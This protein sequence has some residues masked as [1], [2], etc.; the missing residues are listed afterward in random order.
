MKL[1][2]PKLLLTAV[3]AAFLPTT[4]AADSISISFGGT[5]MD[6][7]TDETS[8]LGGITKDGWNIVNIANTNGTAVDNQKGETAGTLVMNNIFGGWDSSVDSTN[9]VTGVV[10]RN[11]IDI[12]NYGGGNVHTIA[13]THNYW[14]AD[15]TYYMSGDAGGTYAPMVINGNTYINGTDNILDEGENPAW[16]SR[17]GVTEYNEN[18]TITVTGLSGGTITA[19]NVY[20]SETARATLGGMQVKDNSE[21]T[22]Y[23]TTLK[24]GITAAAD[25]SWTRDGKVSTYDDI[26]AGKK[27]LG[28]NA[29]AEGSTLQLTGGE[30]IDSIAAITNTV[31][32]QSD[33]A[34]TIYDLYTYSGA[35]IVLDTTATVNSIRGTGNITISS[36]GLLKTSGSGVASSLHTLTGSGRIEVTGAFYIKGNATKDAAGNPYEP[37]VPLDISYAGTIA[38]DADSMLTIGSNVTGGY[39]HAG[40]AVNMDDMTIELN[41]GGIHFNGGNSTLGTLVV[42]GTNTL[43]TEDSRVDGEGLTIKNLKIQGDLNLTVHWKGTLRI[44][45]ITENTG[46]LTNAATT[47]LGADENSI[48]NLSGTVK[49]T[50]K[51]TLNGDVRISE[52][53]TKFK[54]VKEGENRELSVNGTDG[55]QTITDNTYLLIDN[56]NGTVTLNPETALYQGAS[57]KLTQDTTTG[58][59]TFIGS[60]SMDT[61]YRVNTKDVTF[62]G[63]NASDHTERATG[64]IVAK[65][66]TLT[67]AGDGKEVTAEDILLNTTGEGNVT[68]TTDVRLTAQQ[69]SQ[70]TG[71]LTVSNCKLELAG[72]NDNFA[73][74]SSFKESVTL[75][76]AKVEF[77]NQADTFTNVTVT[78]NGASLELFDMGAP[79]DNKALT[80]AGTTTL[81]GDLNLTSTWNSQLHI[82]K[83]KGTGNL[84]IND[85]ETRGYENFRMQ[86]LVIN[87]AGADQYSGQIQIHENYDKLN[88]TVAENAGVNVALINVD[89]KSGRNQIAAIQ[90]IGSGNTITL[91]GVT[92]Y[93]PEGYTFV[94]DIVLK[95]TEGENAKAALEITDG[96]TKET[97]EFSGKVSGS[98]NFLINKPTAAVHMTYK[99]SGDVSQWEGSMEV[100]GGEHDVVYTD[101]N[102][103]A[104]TA[105]VV[106]N[107]SIKSR[108]K[109]RNNV[110]FDYS[111][112]AT[113]KS[114]FENGGNGLYLTVKN[115]SKDATTFTSN[116]IG[117]NKLTVENGKA[118]FTG[119]DTLTMAEIA[120]TA[121]AQLSVGAEGTGTVRATTAELAAG[122]VITGNFDLS[123]ATHLTLDGLGTK[124]VT[125]TGVLVMD[126]ATKLTLN[127]DTIAAITALDA[128]ERLNLFTVGSFTVG[129]AAPTTE[130]IADAVQEYSME[131]FFN[132]TWDERLYL[133]F[134]GTEI[135]VVNTS[136][137]PEPTTATLSLLALAALAAR[138]R[139]R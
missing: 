137:I 52:D 42:K 86:E 108:D 123:Q 120:L 95:N 125:V 8:E 15:V 4:N 82:E 111:R 103:A 51:L 138:R 39:T 45:S 26:K 64:A 44:D 12:K 116:A 27:N 133:G 24:N 112:A 22:G 105:I 60:S 35:G 41:G 74:I 107:S 91:S 77:N 130:T 48:L 68:L 83:L 14:L 98:G 136:T 99:F 63:D 13:L 104:G 11:Y 90:N 2:L 3:L 28:I 69:N 75:D 30:T 55:Y 80:F 9:T 139:R 109:G 49:N 59:V 61:I 43:H 17:G 46:S 34:V 23:F 57:I 93:L 79:E 127:A 5:T 71:T 33:E 10:Q 37:G 135:Y 56:D 84:V 73:S 20:T 58:D 72:G 129:A 110:T 65:G 87:I 115:S 54:M 18:N 131:T 94:N 132:G 7:V 89:L 40:W 25:A 76:N 53:T 92:G 47:I 134:N 21:T 106:N 102:I 6:K 78:K 70:A 67:I 36:N 31:T 124:T 117:L 114:S 113:V 32:L 81:N 119:V 85:T 101:A 128:Q 29:H 100:I 16:G 19:Q 66:R 96:W 97:N 62:G 38:M 50:G 1:H 121:T 126:S 88:L 118:A 122:A